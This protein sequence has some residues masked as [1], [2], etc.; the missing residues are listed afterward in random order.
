MADYLAKKGT[1]IS[2]MF[3]CKLSC[4]SAKLKTSSTQT[5]LTRYYTIQIQHKPWNKTAEKR[6]MAP[7]SPREDTVAIF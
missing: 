7:D 3:T 2:Q 5:D 4:H 6:Y 1:A